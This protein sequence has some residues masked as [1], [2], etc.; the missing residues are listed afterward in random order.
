MTGSRNVRVRA[1]VSG[2]LGL[3]LFGLIGCGSKP[4]DKAELPPPIVTMAPPVQQPVTQYEFATGH[5]VPLEEVKVQ[6][7]VSG[8]LKKIY[9]EKGGVEVDKGAGSVAAVI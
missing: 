1:A 6:S 4:G 9:F 3:I 2:G 5:T 8:V 7:R